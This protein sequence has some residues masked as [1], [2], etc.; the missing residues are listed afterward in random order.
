MAR[1]TPLMFIIPLI[2][3]IISFG[4]LM[5]VVF[6]GW[7]GPSQNVGGNFCEVSDGLIKQ[8]ANTWS[9]LGFIC[10]GLTIG[11]LMMRGRFAEY[12]NAFTSSNFTPIFFASL[13]VFLGPASMAMHAT[14]TQIGGDLDM[15]SMYLVAAFMTGYAMQRFFRW[16]ALQF[17]VVFVLVILLCE[18]AGTFHQHIF[19]VHYAG[20]AAFGFFIILASVFEM[21]NTYIRKFTIEKRWGYYAL[22]SLITAF[23]IW[24]FWTND[25]PLCDPKS[26][27]QGHAIWHLLDALAVFFLFRFYV[28][29][30]SERVA[31]AQSK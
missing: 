15:L 19:L 5:L 23:I 16:G 20:N 25:S 2:V 24:N 4:G 27:I 14:L 17:T 1:R 11:W 31:S 30:Q 7:F 9:N 8:R 29:E 12:H 13:A 26:W 18:W 10:A 22:G 28:S 6:N 21:M 3:A